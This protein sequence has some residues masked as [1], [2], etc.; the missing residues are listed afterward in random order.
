MSP[1][2]SKGIAQSSQRKDNSRNIYNSKGGDERPS[3]K[4]RLISGSPK[5]QP[6]LNSVWVNAS[7]SAL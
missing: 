1:I 4:K 2:I 3:Y 7:R 5:I 6:S